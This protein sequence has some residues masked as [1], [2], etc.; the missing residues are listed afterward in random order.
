MT[1]IYRTRKTNE[2][3]CVTFNSWKAFLN[4]AY[5]VYQSKLTLARK[6]DNIFE[7]MCDGIASDVI[8]TIKGN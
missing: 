5:A 4:E 2:L 7:D 6:I 3:R 1:L 8:N